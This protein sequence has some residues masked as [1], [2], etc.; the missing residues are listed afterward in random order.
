MAAERVSW[1]LF[2]FADPPLP[3][4]LGWQRHLGQ[5]VARR[6]FGVPYHDMTCPFRLARRAIFG[7]IP[8]Q[9]DG[10]FAHVEILAK[11]NFIGCLLGEEVPLGERQRRCRRGRVGTI[12]VICWPRAIVSWATLI[13]AR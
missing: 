10:A 9:S 13:S 6:L 8:L 2:G 3:G 5:W 4:W 1:L 7:R 11:A 12:A